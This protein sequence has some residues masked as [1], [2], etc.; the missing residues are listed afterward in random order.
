LFHVWVEQSRHPTDKAANKASGVYG[1][2]GLWAVSMP[3]TNSALAIQAF[4]SVELGQ[5]F[6]ARFRNGDD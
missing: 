2:H 4:W 6:T 5:R 1:P 3:I